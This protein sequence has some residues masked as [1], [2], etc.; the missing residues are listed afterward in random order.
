MLSN[1]EGLKPLLG[2]NVPSPDAAGNWLRRM[3]SGA[4]LSA[5]KVVQNKQLKW[6][7]KRESVKGYTLDRR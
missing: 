5:L 3:G 1:D 6:S 7:M 4:G 2:M